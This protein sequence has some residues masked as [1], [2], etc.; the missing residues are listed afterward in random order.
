MGNLELSGVTTK[1][2]SGQATA[3]TLARVE[4]GIARV[5]ERLEA[6][7]NEEDEDGY[8]NRPTEHALQI[9]LDLLQSAYPLVGAGLPRPIITPDGLGGIRIEWR[10][11]GEDIRLVCPAEPTGRLYIY[12]NLVDESNPG[13]RGLDENIDHRATAYWL[14]RLL[15]S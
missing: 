5:T 10:Q 14:Y 8:I 15:N 1:H 6:L 7:R 4:T 9:T 2:D 12:Y 11:G 3:A 13:A